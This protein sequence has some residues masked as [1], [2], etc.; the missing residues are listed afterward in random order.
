M[1]HEF[2]RRAKG[3]FVLV[4]RSP[5]ATEPLDEAKE[6]ARIKQELIAEGQKPS[7]GR[8]DRRMKRLRGAPLEDEKDVRTKKMSERAEARSKST[9]SK[10][11]PP[12]AP[13]ACEEWR[14]RLQ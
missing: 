7:P 3:T 11:K 5:M 6:K 10:P 13:A 2:A 14:L 12:A 4:G 9:P 1:A 8:V